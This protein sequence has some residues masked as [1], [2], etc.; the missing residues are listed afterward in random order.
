M[1]TAWNLEALLDTEL[2]CL[3]VFS[4]RSFSLHALVP[5]TYHLVSGDLGIRAL[6]SFLLF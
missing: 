3:D 1:I 6:V 2:C 4:D 5:K